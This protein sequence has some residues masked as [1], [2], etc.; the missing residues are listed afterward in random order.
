MLVMLQVLD[1]FILIYTIMIF[2]RVLGSW[3]PEWQSTTFMRFISQYT[4]PYLNFFRSIIP[5][6]GMFDFSAMVAIIALQIFKSIFAR[7]LIG[8][9]A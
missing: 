8:V 7:L 6:L 2:V 4:D 9:M 3:V 5:P 1:K